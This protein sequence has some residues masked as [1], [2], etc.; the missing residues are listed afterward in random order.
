[1][2]PWSE[3][4]G[5]SKAL[6]WS[7][8]ITFV[9]ALG[10]GAWFFVWRLAPEAGHETM[11]VGIGLANTLI[12]SIF[13]LHHSV[14][15]RTGAK[16]WLLRVVP[17]TLERTT[18]VW[19]ASLLF[20][21][22][23]TLW[24]PTRDVAWRLPGA[25]AWIGVAIQALG[26]LVT[27]LAAQRIDI[28]DLSGVRTASGPL[29]PLTAE[30]PFGFVRHPIYFGWVL[31]VWAAPVMSSGRLLFAAVS[32][33]YL[34]VAIPLEERSL[35]ALHGDAYRRYRARVRWRLVPGIY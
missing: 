27:G 7:G 29:D 13:A 4:S 21:G 11:S 15:A 30:G 2:P 25:A 35:E 8:A 6:A 23:C 24:R 19:V 9:I 14:M 16:A 5:L 20:L 22:V 28:W 17:P 10:A 34:V 1:M 32:T 33:F 3:R 12:F 26:L 31:M 18:F